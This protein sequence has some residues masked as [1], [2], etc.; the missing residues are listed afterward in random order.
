V[1]ESDAALRWRE[2]S[3]EQRS[4][5]Y[6]DW[7]IAWARERVGAPEHA[8]GVL[9]NITTAET[10]HTERGRLFGEWQAELLRRL[11]AEHGVEGSPLPGY[12]QPG[13]RQPQPHPWVSLRAEETKQWQL[14]ERYCFDALAQATAERAE[15]VEDA[16]RRH[17]EANPGNPYLPGSG[18]VL[19]AGSKTTADDWLR[20]HEAVALARYEASVAAAQPTPASVQ[21]SFSPLHRGVKRSASEWLAEERQALDARRAQREQAARELT[22]RRAERGKGDGRV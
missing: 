2:L 22:D 10:Q 1:A 15:A 5:I 13:A 17:A 6:W 7:S 8:P 20:R 9:G 11:R 12:Y 18:S 4:A 19:H 16:R 3:P 14:M 21:G